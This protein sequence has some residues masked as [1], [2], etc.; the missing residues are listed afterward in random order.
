VSL[1][2]F[3]A[4][5]LFAGALAVAGEVPPGSVPA[6]VVTTNEPPDDWMD[7]ANDAVHQTLE[8]P[9]KWF[10]NLFA[11][12]KQENERI[13]NSTFRTK[14]VLGV[15]EYQGTEVSFAPTFTMDLYLPHLDRQFHLLLRSD[16]PD[17]LPD[18]DPVQED[19]SPLLGL[20]VARDAGPWGD[21]SVNGGVKIG[22]LPQPYGETAWRRIFQVGDL[23]IVPRERL[24]WIGGEGFGELTTLR[25]VRPIGS[26][27]IADARSGAL[28]SETTDGVEWSQSL[29]VGW[30]W[31]GY[32]PRRVIRS[33]MVGVKGVIF[34][35]KNGS[36]VIDRY[37]VQGLFRY[38]LHR[39]WLFVDVVPYVDFPN[40]H[41]WNAVPAVLVALDIFWDGPRQR[42]QTETIVEEFPDVQEELEEP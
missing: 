22:S 34:G 3:V 12:D 23:R 21:F 26:Q 9:V 33:P 39:D 14:F 32:D 31:Q 36:G 5:I 6:S 10:D 8:K 24:F 25:L 27:L 4:A 41:D 13:Q 19:S 35:H 40:D 15:K 17:E 30:F 37:R 16:N 2:G 7:N 38:R 11:P 1:A 20:G 29:G 18:R 42:T 28:W